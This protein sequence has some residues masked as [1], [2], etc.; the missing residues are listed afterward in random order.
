MVQILTVSSTGSGTTPLHEA[1][2]DGVDA[3][4]RH[5]FT[6]LMYTSAQDNSA[7]VKLL[8]QKK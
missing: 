2:Y 6:P 3:K 5:N 4:D 8:L 7:M 1:A